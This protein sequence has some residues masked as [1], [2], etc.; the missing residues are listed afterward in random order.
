[1]EV[2]L[3][4]DSFDTIE[5]IDKCITF[6][7]TKRFF[8]PGQ[9][10]MSL[11]SDVGSFRS[12]FAIYEPFSKG[13]YLIERIE[14]GDKGI[15]K[16]GGRSLEALLENRILEGNGRYV[17]GAEESV[18]LAVQRN[19]TN[20]RALSGLVLGDVTGLVGKGCFNTDYRN[21]SEFVYSSLRP[22]GGTYTIE[23]VGSI[24]TFRVITGRDRTRSQNRYPSVVFS[25]SMGNVISGSTRF[26]VKDSKNIAY[27]SG[28]DGRR[29]IAAISD[30]IVDRREV[31]VNARDISP[32][33]FNT[34]EEYLDALRVRGLETLTRYGG[35]WKYSGNVIG[36]RYGTD[37]F[38][39]DICDIDT[40]LGVS[41]SERITSV[42]FVFENGTVRS[43]VTFGEGEEPL[44]S[45][46]KEYVSVTV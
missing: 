45:V 3:L 26:D 6:K 7:A 27:V 22:F 14:C 2:Y 44:R 8:S 25:E 40:C 33:E 17:G 31:Y 20:E 5:I 38:L 24:P 21:L 28:S 19:T 32:H 1:M 12:A 9:F 16:I 43:T 35:E 13:S 36:T 30:Q 39:G 15:V 37:Y 11:Y 23:L 34:D 42:E 29:V 46:I 41:F 4:D 10:E 18:R